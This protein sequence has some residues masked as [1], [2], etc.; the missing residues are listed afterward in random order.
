MVA[1]RF[2]VAI[3][4]LMLLAS[5]MDGP[6][7][8]LRLASSVNTNP[9]VVR[10]ITGLLARAGLI[11]VRRGPGGAVL[12]RPT[13]QITL[14]DVWKAINPGCQRPL[15]PIHMHPDPLCPVGAKVQGVLSQAFVLAERAMHEALGRTALSD[16]VAGLDLPAACLVQAKMPSMA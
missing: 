3:H 1:T 9:V 4:I 13:E 2:A 12:A 16:L 8:S 7:T 14:A 5:H 15:L 6:A 11:R 10:R